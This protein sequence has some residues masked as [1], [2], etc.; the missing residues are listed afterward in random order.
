M[1]EYVAAQVG[2]M[3]RLSRGHGLVLCQTGRRQRVAIAA[4]VGDR[5]IG[6]VE[7]FGRDFTGNRSLGAGRSHGSIPDQFHANVE[8]APNEFD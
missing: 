1:G 8:D 5:K 7:R 4:V 6:V 3:E 2:P